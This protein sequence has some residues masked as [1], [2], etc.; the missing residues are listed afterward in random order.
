MSFSQSLD[1]G[2]ATTN[3]EE[4]K[5]RREGEATTEAR[6]DSVQDRR[7]TRRRGRLVGCDTTS[8][9]NSSETHGRDSKS[10]GEGEG[11]SRQREMVT[12]H[13]TCASKARQRDEVRSSKSCSPTRAP[14]CITRL[15]S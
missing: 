3:S 1:V 10:C 2:Q 4:S 6:Q 8:S 14:A 15:M 13:L 5:E 11:V 7:E 12:E 9:C